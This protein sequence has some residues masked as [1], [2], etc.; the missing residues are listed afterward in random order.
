MH[1]VHAADGI[2]PQTC[3]APL[4]MCDGGSLGN[5]QKSEEDKHLIVAMSSGDDEAASGA[6][7]V[8]A[9]WVAAR[10]Q[11]DDSCRKWDYR[12][13]SPGAGTPFGTLTGLLSSEQLLRWRS[14]QVAVYEAPTALFC[15]SRFAVGLSQRAMSERC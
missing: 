5:R 11:G 15:S 13:G 2:K 6:V 9:Y 1:S 3:G 14:E 10:Q 12:T 4:K 7:H 8:R